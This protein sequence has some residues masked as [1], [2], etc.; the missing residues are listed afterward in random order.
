M[1]SGKKV[2]IVGAGVSGCSIAYHL[3]RRGVASTIVERESIG[4]RASGKAW[5]VIAYP[6]SDVLHERLPPDLGG[7]ANPLQGLD[8]I[9][10]EAEG[11]ASWIDLFWMGYFGIRDLVRGIEQDSGIDVGF[12]EGRHTLLV[13][14][15]HDPRSARDRLLALVR[16]IAA[17][18]YQWIDADELRA[19]VPGISRAFVGGL[20]SPEFQIEP[21]KFTL[22]L[23]QAAEKRGVEIRHG[24]VVSFGT[25]GDRVTSVRLASGHE[26]D[27]EA[28]VLAVGPWSEQLAAKLGCELPIANALDDCIRVEVDEPLPLHSLSYEDSWIIPLRDGDVI[29]ASWHDGVE[30][31]RRSD[32]DASLSDEAAL[33]VMARVTRI[34]PSL[35][36]ARLVE[37]RGD[38]LAYAPPAPCER[39]VLGRIPGWENAH[40][41][42]RFG[43]SGMMLSPG[44]GE[45]MAGLVAD[46]SIPLRARQLM[47]VLSP[48]PRR[49]LPDADLHE[50]LDRSP[51]RVGSQ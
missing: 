22:A 19:S 25:R 15:S 41:A 8:S 16:G 9:P 47:D 29:C 13:D 14:D 3:A 40:V 46:G 32:F 11:Y 26:L 6:P 50:D 36:Q 7:D 48:A 5:A 51:R 21:Y 2:V 43:G 34:L 18:E 24:E 30:S 45:L 33:Q 44:V 28:V 4:T 1:S 49:D 39:P 37:H 27:A 17:S 10:S 12:A 31:R 23:A 20:S 42:T 35:E 38:L